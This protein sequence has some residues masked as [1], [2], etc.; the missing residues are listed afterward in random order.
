MR[1]YVR[2]T[3]APHDNRADLKN[4]RAVYP[5][6]REYLGRVLLALACLILAKVANVGV[7]VV[8]KG[9]VDKLDASKQATLALPVVLLLAYGALRLSGGLFNELRD[10]LF[11]RVRYRAMRRLATRL[12]DHL[13]SLSL[14]F[15]LERRTGAIS[16][17]L[18]RGTQSVSSLLNYLTFSI[19]PTLVEFALVAVIL[20][21]S[22]HAKFVLITFGTVAV[23]IVFTLLVA[24]WRMHYR[25]SMNAL[26]SEANNQ[27]VDGLINYETVK[28]FG[29]AQYE[30]QRYDGTLS[31]WEDMAVKSQTSMSVLNFGQGAIIAIGVTTVMFYAAGG[32]AD[33]SMTLGD[34]VMVNALMLQL[35]MPLSVLGVVFRQTVHA[36]ADMDMMFRLL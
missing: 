5:F 1:G 4:L 21:G 11:A 29:N 17:D 28:Y 18:E 19:V 30:V 20:F 22:Y 16:R 26:D 36:L 14:R 7:P 31:Q 2:Y 34:L 27:A 32:V 9:I 10:A 15:H 33:G 23:Y 35:F 3:Q 24:Q 6:L 25:H 13:Y 8:L 12:L